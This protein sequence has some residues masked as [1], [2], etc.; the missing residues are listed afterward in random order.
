[1]RIRQARATQALGRLERQEARQQAKQARSIDTRRKLL[2]GAM[3]LEWVRLGWVDG[4][5]FRA[6]MRAYLTRE[7]DKALFADDLAPAPDRRQR[8]K[9][10]NR[11]KVLTGALILE[12]V[13]RGIIPKDQFLAMMGEYLRRDVDRRVFD[14]SPASTLLEAGDRGDQ[15]EADRLLSKLEVPAHTLM[16]IKNSLP[17]GADWI[18]SMNLNTRLADEK[19][20]PGWL[21]R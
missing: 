15:A 21:D 16:A 7:Q 8:H 20:G 9:R 5:G 6:H 17:G 4:Y 10:S 1:M 18:R 13:E 11:Q 2:A 19:Y 12:W 3:V 14:L